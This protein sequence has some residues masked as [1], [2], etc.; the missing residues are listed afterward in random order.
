MP[1]EARPIGRRHPNI[2]PTFLS[3]GVYVVTLLHGPGSA[4]PTTYIPRSARRTT[5]IIAALSQ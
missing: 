4:P 2:S 3:A 1:T 5:G